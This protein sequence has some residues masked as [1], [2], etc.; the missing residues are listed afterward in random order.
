MPHAHRRHC[1]IVQDCNSALN[2]A[3]KHPEIVALLEAAQLS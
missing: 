1:R 3:R 2:R